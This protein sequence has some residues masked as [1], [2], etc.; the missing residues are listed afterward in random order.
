M[1]LQETV[2]YQ[3]KKWI[4]EVVIGCNFCPFAS[5]VVKKNLVHYEVEDS[6][7]AGTCFKTAL[8]LIKK[9]DEKTEIETAFLI[10]PAACADFDSYLKLV[11]DLEWQLVKRG[12]SGIYQV[13]SFH[14]LYQFA[15]SVYDDAANYTNRSIYPMLHIL[16]ED[17]IANALK[18]YHQPESIPETNI[19]FARSKGLTYMKMLRDA[20]FN[21]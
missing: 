14:P 12:Y 8:L 1:N 19:N 4:N 16:R 3:T 11:S 2:I 18:N 20:C 15:G 10:M 17:S 9:L 21:L 6:S 13:A 7:D 5:N